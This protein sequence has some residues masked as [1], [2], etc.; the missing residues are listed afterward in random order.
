MNSLLKQTNTET[1]GTPE[2]FVTEFE[3]KILAY[4][5]LE[6]ELI[7]TKL[8]FLGVNYDPFNPEVT[9]ECQQ[10]MENLG[11]TDHLQNPYL[12]TNILL[13]LLDKTEERVNNLK[14]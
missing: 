1:T 7:M 3:K 6:A 2:D 5:I 12:A 9:T 11:L 8:K 10:I 14:Q 13:R 4:G